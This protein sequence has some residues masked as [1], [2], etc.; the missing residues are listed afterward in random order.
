M[1][2]E[3]VSEQVEQEEKRRT[4][5]RKT[6]SDFQNS[7]L[8]HHGTGTLDRLSEFC[9]EHKCTYVEGSP[10]KSAFNE[11]ARSVI[12]E[13]RHWLDYDLTKLER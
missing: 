5:I 13:I 10:G 4:L 12:L 3:E 1:E 7:F 11:G 6:V 8:S 9:M 2:P